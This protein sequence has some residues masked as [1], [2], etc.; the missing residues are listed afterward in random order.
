MIKKW[1]WR[2]NMIENL[3]VEQFGEVFKKLFHAYDL[4]I[5]KIEYNGLEDFD[6]DMELRSVGISMVM[7]EMPDWKTKEL[8]QSRIKVE[9]R[10]CDFDFVERDGRKLNVKTPSQF[11]KRYQSYILEQFEKT[12]NKMAEKYQREIEN[13]NFIFEDN[14]KI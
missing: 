9:A 3:N 13:R 4:K 6:E 7:L 10:D 1:H 2:K 12:S 14:I 5:Y 8:K 11:V